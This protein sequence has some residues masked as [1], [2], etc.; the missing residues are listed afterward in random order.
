MRGGSTASARCRITK[1]SR[2]TPYAIPLAEHWGTFTECQ[3]A[4][5][6]VSNLLDLV[7]GRSRTKKGK[8][9]KVVTRERL[10]RLTR[11]HGI[12]GDVEAFLVALGVKVAE[13]KLVA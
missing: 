1:S 10:E 5:L 12:S 9:P 7:K 11:T 8:G 6:S 13:V 3:R 2:H 4:K